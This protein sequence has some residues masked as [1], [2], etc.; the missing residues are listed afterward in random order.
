M[1]TFR[2]RSGNWQVRIQ[3]K[4]GPTQTRTFTNLSDAKQW[5]RKV[6]R[7][8]DLG[9]ND[10]QPRMITLKE[11]LIR[12]LNEVTPRKKRPEIETYRIKAWLNHELSQKL[13]SQIKT[14]HLALWRD[15]KIRLGFQPNT[16]RI[17]LA[18][19]SHLYTTAQSEWGYDHLRNPVVNLS[20]PRL[21]PARDSRI[22]DKDIEL[23]IQNTKSPYLPTLI[24]L[25]LYSAMR[26]SELIKLQ[27]QDIDWE[28]GVIHL[29]DTKNGDNRRVPLFDSIKEL[30]QP[31]AQDEGQVFPMTEHAVSIAFRRAVLRSDLKNISFHTLRHEAITRFFEEGLG[32]PQVASIS[33]HKSWGMLKRYTHL[34][35]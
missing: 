35:I 34:N 18:V 9:V 28:R 23:L 6:E 4:D 30:L 5:A 24:R 33:G 20:R 25:G 29:K 19:L 27:W 1:A 14:Q 22:S 7:E 15:E 21:P 10:L 26:R 3:R 2:R 13:I 17:H 32:I 12:Y 11:A 31:I 16:I 8:Y